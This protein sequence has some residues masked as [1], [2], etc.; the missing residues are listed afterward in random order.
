MAQVLKKYA[1]WDALFRTFSLVRNMWK[2][3]THPTSASDFF[4]LLYPITS[5]RPANAMEPEII[6]KKSWRVKSICWILFYFAC[7]FR[8]L[9][10]LLLSKLYLTHPQHIFN[11]FKLPSR[12]EFAEDQD[13]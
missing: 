8:M 6:N 7:T 9:F 11:F 12:L 13:D 10:G 1:F 5:L 4:L 2:D 3:S